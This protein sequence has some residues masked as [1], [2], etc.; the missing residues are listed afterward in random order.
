MLTTINEYL[1]YLESVKNFSENT[2]TSYKKDLTELTNFLQ[3]TTG[4]VPTPE[5]LDKRHIRSFLKNQ[6]K[7]NKSKRTYNR[8][9]ASIKSL[10]KY[11]LKNEIIKKDIVSTIHSLKE[12]RNLPEFVTKEQTDIIN[13]KL[14]VTDFFS[15]REAML[16]ELFYSTGLRLSELWSLSVSDLNK[17]K[18]SVIG[19]GSKQRLV[20]ITKFVKQ[21]LKEY[22]PYREEVLNDKG[23]ITEY[24][25]IS[26]NGKHLTKRQIRN[27]VSKLISRMADVN[28]TS[29]HVLRH[30]FAT[31][32]L[33]NG[34]DIMSVKELLGHESLS[35]TQ[36][37]TH[38][39]L[40]KLKE[41]YKKAHPKG[42]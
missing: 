9:L 5:E 14:Y 36:I 23:E 18:I 32:L 28:K 31:H 33:D 2:V 25:F 4:N 21:R 3:E 35:T 6:I 38:V 37:Y 39:S 11:L 7:T 16:F 29:P 8:K 13:Y 27:V 12:E 42:E 26:R 10:V 34:A 20:P 19:K 17:D 24:L 1:K 30:T 40:E 22:L 41:V 15:A